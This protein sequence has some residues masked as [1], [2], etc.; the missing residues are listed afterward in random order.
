MKFFK[1]LKKGDVICSK[2]GKK[3]KVIDLEVNWIGKNACSHKSVISHAEIKNN[4]R[5]SHE[6]N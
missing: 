6:R 2:I 1:A 5:I 4:W 3:Y